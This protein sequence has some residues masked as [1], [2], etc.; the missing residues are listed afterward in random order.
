MD[1]LESEG[2]RAS[3]HHRA[4]SPYVHQSS[5]KTSQGERRETVLHWHV[6]YKR[7][8][9]KTVVWKSHISVEVPKLNSHICLLREGKDRLGLKSHSLLDRRGRG[10]P[11]AALSLR[12]WHPKAS[13]PYSP[14]R[15]LES[16]LWRIPQP[17][18]VLSVPRTTM[19]RLVCAS[20]QRRMTGR[21]PLIRSIGKC[22]WWGRSW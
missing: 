7:S 3:L 11:R 10:S 22:R 15:C 20:S 12:W 8:R 5:M 9:P 1:C 21:G 13:R 14:Y 18:L 17:Y 4:I 2:L 6:D 19:E 16:H